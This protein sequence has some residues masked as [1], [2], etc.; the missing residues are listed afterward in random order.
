MMIA[1]VGLEIHAKSGIFTDTYIF[2]EDSALY[3]SSA[4][5]IAVIEDHRLLDDGA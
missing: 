4:T 5:D 1:A 3:V 2:V